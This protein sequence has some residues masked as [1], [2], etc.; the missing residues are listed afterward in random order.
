VELDIIF[1]LSLF[2]RRSLQPEELRR[3]PII[4]AGD[5]LQ[6]INPTGFRWDAVQADFHDRF[7]AVLDPRRRSRIELSYRELR[8]NYRSNPGIVRFCNLIQLVRAALLG[9]S[10][11]TPQEAW[12]VDAPVQTVWFAL[13]NAETKQQ[14]E[15][16]P[17]LVKLVNCEEGEETD[18]VRADPILKNLK[19]EAEGI[20]RNVLGPTR[21]KGLEF[22][23]VVVYRYGESAP[24]NFVRLLRGEIDIEEP[25]ERLPHEYFLN[26][27]YVA[28]S[29]AK[30]QL[31]VV[32]SGRALESFW[33]FATDPDVID[34]LIE[35]AGGADVWKNAIT[36]LVPGKEQAWSGERIDPKEQAA[37]YAIQGRRKRDPYLLRQAALAYRSAGDEF[38]AGKS[39]ALAAEFEGRRKEAGDKYLELGLYEDSFRCYWEGRS[40]ASLCELTA[41]E[42]ALTSRLES[43]AAD[44][45][46][47]GSAPL[48][49]FLAG[50]VDAAGSPDWRYDACQD[51]SW[52]EVLRRVAEQLSKAIRNK[53]LPWNKLLSVFDILVAGGVPIEDAHLAAIAYAANDFGRAIQLWERVSTPESDEYR[54]A[55]AHIE[56]FPKN[57]RWFNSLKEHKQVLQEWQKHC[58]ELPD[59]SKMDDWVIAAVADSALAEGDL[60]LAAEMLEVRPDKERAGKLLLAAANKGEAELI[61]ILHQSDLTM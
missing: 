8:F 1:Q 33:R 19:E 29:R 3:V 14:L 26:R 37:E 16:R 59:P 11:M 13:D 7:N 12:W 9:S 44:F 10:D 48:P 51:A 42:F 47:R 56:L 50:I 52:Q 60:P 21:A 35:R 31:V 61:P 24:A 20:Y 57:L 36:Y 4:F 6:T 34:Q 5:P 22:P 27:L 18:F 53:S 28:A 49:A 23:A 39:L 46:N 41:R 15:R 30:G 25:E 17:D 54:R 58:T 43:Q 40:W 45:M 38:E 2:A 32:D 55:K